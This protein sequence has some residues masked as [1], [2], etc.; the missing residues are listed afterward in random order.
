[1]TTRRRGRLIASGRS[2]DVFEYAPGLVL[3]RYRDEIDAEGE[4]VVMEHARAHGFPVPAVHEAE[5]RDLVLER[6]DG[7]TRLADL[8][9]HP[10]LLT[11]HAAAL[12]ALH[13]RLHAVRA[14]DGLQA[15]FGDEETLLHLDL[16][17]GN[18]LLA[19]RGPVVID[20]ANA[21][22]GDG[23]AD[24]AQTWMLLATSTIEGGAIE[25]SILR[26]GRRLFLETFLRRTDRIA[27][28]RRLSDVARARLDDPNVRADERA[29][30]LRLSTS[31]GRV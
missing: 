14:P 30:L 27:A 31:T 9:R 2:A 16:H 19:E 4:A 23:A 8:A 24:L 11:S 3:R 7:P 28:A 29:A 5:G 20:W 6:V 21:A 12:A 13:R 15:R 26:A 1:M 22:R 18:V 10:W 25:R 17:P